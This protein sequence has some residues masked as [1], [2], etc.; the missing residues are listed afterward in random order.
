M[1]RDRKL[2]YL[3]NKEKELV[4]CK[5]Y[6]EEHKEEIVY[7]RRINAENHNK[8]W[9][10][11]NRQIKQKCVDYLGGKCSICGYNKCLGSMDFHHID[12]KT[13]EFSI[14]PGMYRYFYKNWELLKQE[15]D[16]CI[17]LCANCHGEIHY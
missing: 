7:K 17:L 16:K 13:K 12:P 8:K 15:L 3:K 2:Q 9:N 10:I 14:S 11:R 4:Q 1:S 6:R 5:K